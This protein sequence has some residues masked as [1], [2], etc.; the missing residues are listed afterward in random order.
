[1][2]CVDPKK[3]D[4]KSIK[5]QGQSNRL[6]VDKIGIGR[7]PADSSSASDSDA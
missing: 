3:F 2:L 7:T 4:A 5:D 1:M 6:W